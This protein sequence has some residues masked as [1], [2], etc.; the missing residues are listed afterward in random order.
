VRSGLV[1]IVPLTAACAAKGPATV[2]LVPREEARRATVDAAP[3]ATPALAPYRTLWA[4]RMGGRDTQALDSAAIDGNGNIALVGSGFDPDFGT[5][6]LRDPAAPKDRH[7]FLVELD[8]SGKTRCAKLLP[9]TDPFSVHIAFDRAGD[10]FLAGS[11]ATPT[12]DLGLPAPLARRSDIDVFVAKLDAAGR[13]LWARS[14]GGDHEQM[15][16]GLTVDPMGSVVVLG[17]FTG[18]WIDLG[19]GPLQNAG[20]TDIFA[21]SLGGDG[22]HRWARTFGGAGVDQAFSLAADAR[23]LVY[24]GGFF[25]QRVD[26]GAGAVLETAG[27]TDAFVVALDGDG[28]T[29]WAR[30]FG[31]KERDGLLTLAVK[32]NG[33]VAFTASVGGPVDL[34]VGPILRP[35]HALFGLD[36]TGHVRWAR[37]APVGDEV[38][39]V[40]AEGRLEVIAGPRN[41]GLLLTTFSKVGAVLSEERIGS[42]TVYLRRPLV[43]RRTGTLIVVGEPSG[44]IDLGTGS[45]AGVDKDVFAAALAR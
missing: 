37:P 15:T 9:T 3:R 18:R 45:L 24:V 38:P 21:V 10:L 35:G 22:R 8:P 26:F 4:R 43:D 34:G 20:Q 6:I 12:L 36:P 19:Q 42:G 27:S 31:G 25:G 17:W 7:T 41:A 5:G 1:S 44:T 23:G 28:G 14:F 11:F 16:T 2:E 39:F 33:P 29:A 30:R 13:T 32:G 40:D